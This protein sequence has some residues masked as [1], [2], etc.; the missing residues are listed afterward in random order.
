MGLGQNLL[1]KFIVMCD[2]L[3]PH[4]DL[5]KIVCWM[6]LCTTVP[7]A[8]KSTCKTKV[9][10]HTSTA[11]IFNGGRN[12]ELLHPQGKTTRAVQDNCKPHAT[13]S[14]W[15]AYYINACLQAHANVHH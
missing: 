5:I 12:T 1:C 13:Q 4:S 9:V 10:L 15:L 14:S 6:S 7:H 8:A 11:T 2:S 3:L